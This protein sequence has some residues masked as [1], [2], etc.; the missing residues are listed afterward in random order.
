VSVQVKYNSDIT[1]L[2]YKAHLVAKGF[3]QNPGIDYAETFNPVVKA[4]TISVLFSL[5]VM[6]GWDIQQMDINNAFLN[7]E[8]NEEVF[9]SQPKEFVDSQF[10]NYVQIKEVA[11]WAQTGS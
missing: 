5:T 11:L 8:L 3:L 1:I 7:G 4:P 6:F 2:K 10:P 9:M